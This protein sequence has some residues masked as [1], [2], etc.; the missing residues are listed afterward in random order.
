MI[1]RDKNL[2][3]L[4][5]EFP[6]RAKSFL[7]LRD[8]DLE[9]VSLSLKFLPRPII[10]CRRVGGEWVFDTIDAE[11]MEQDLIDGNANLY[12][13]EFSGKA[14]MYVDTAEGTVIVFM[15]DDIADDLRHIYGDA[16]LPGKQREAFDT[17]ISRT[18]GD[19]RKKALALKNLGVG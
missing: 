1:L 13:F 19:Y 8:D 3:Y 7:F 5:M 16:A 4:N 17:L 12:F 9:M 18:T 10:S 15:S 11:D 6:A 2:S 14:L